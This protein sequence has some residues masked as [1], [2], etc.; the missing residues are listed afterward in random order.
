MMLS[1]EPTNRG[2]KTEHAL[3]EAVGPPADFRVDL[4][5]QYVAGG[6]G[7][8]AKWWLEGGMP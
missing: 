8:I 6:L 7:A 5:A 1:R 3:G 4:F 2:R